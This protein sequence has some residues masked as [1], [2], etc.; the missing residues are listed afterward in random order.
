MSAKITVLAG[1][2]VPLILAGCLIVPGPRGG[3][4]VL[5]PPLPPIV[6]L[7]AE[8]YYVH[9]GYYYYYRDNGWYYSRSRGGPWVDLP[10]DRYPRE[11]R[12]RNGGD[13][14]GGGR[15]PGH[16]GR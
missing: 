7:D 12:F 6:V 1:L 10:R 9:E 2:L 3:G 14:R 11:V 15:N 4:V 8:P 5:A 13:G 16:Q